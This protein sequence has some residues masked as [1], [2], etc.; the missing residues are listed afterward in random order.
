MIS[1]QRL[2]GGVQI[3]QEH[4]LN[5][6]N[7]RHHNSK[8]QTETQQQAEPDNRVYLNERKERLIVHIHISVLYGER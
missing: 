1:S 4:H 3:H 6:N 2:R 5:L 7:N 8:Q